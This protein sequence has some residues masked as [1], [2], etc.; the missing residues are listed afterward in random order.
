MKTANGITLMLIVGTCITAFATRGLADIVG[1]HPSLTWQ[2][3]QGVNYYHQRE[4]KPAVARTGSSPSNSPPSGNGTDL[5][6]HF[7]QSANSIAN[8][9]H[10]NQQVDFEFESFANGSSGIDFI[11]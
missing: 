10:V 3:G 6:V 9:L 8:T 11:D 2:I 1:W 4:T 7:V 5:T